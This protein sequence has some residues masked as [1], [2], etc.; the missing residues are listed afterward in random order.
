[1]IPLGTLSNRHAQG[2]IAAKGLEV[3]ERRG[4]IRRVSEIAASAAGESGASRH[5]ILDIPI[6]SSIHVVS[7]SLRSHCS[8]RAANDSSPEA[9]SREPHS[10]TWGSRRHIPLLGP[11]FSE[12]VSD[13]EREIHGIPSVLA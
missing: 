11:Q 10:V 12:P 13:E 3:F 5:G 8:A 6:V 1:M 9:K 7:P 2:R 4:L